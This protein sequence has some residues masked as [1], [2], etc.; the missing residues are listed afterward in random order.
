VT[1]GGGRSLVAV[2]GLPL[3]ERDLVMGGV[4]M[5]RRRGQSEGVAWVYDNGRELGVE[6]EEGVA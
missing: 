3:S 4:Y 2:Q 1:E 5:Y 6:R